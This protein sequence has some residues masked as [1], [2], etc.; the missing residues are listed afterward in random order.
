MVLRLSTEPNS[1]TWTWTVLIS[2][3]VFMFKLTE[4][5]LDEVIWYKPRIGFPLEAYPTMAIVWA[6]SAVTTIKVS[7]ALVMLSPMA[8]ASEKAN[9]SCSA[10][11]ALLAW[12]PWS[13]FPPV[14]DTM[15]RVC[16]RYKE[17]T[18]FYKG[19]IIL[20]IKQAHKTCFFFTYFD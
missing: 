5:S 12:W 1:N 20:Y 16:L 15:L 10:N 13:I 4:W 3:R 7:S 2:E 17:E 14:I 19:S 11:L 9:V 8:T 18:F 6:W